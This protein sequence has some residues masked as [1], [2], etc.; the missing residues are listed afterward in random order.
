MI[1]HHDFADMPEM[2]LNYLVDMQAET[3]QKFPL[4]QQKLVKNYALR[5]IQNTIAWLRS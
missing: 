2:D 1:S 3:D 5:K 4:L